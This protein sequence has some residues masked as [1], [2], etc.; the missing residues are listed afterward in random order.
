MYEVGTK[1][2]DLYLHWGF[3]KEHPNSA[4]EL[5]EQQCH[6]KESRGWDP[7]GV[8][9]ALHSRFQQDE[10]QENTLVLHLELEDSVVRDRSYLSFVLY[11]RNRDIWHNNNGQDFH[12]ELSLDR[13]RRCDV[14]TEYTMEKEVTEYLEFHHH[15]KLRTHEVLE[16]YL[17]L[18]PEK[19]ADHLTKLL[20]GQALG[21]A[22]TGAGWSSLDTHDSEIF[23]L[24]NSADEETFD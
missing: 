22:P 21:V 16:Y 23:I 13:F 19:V 20:E 4:W 10:S 8:S 14:E 17:S 5:P 18:T 12:I 7:D 24:K 1:I 11:E 6:P 2:D 15:Q 9:T 3:S